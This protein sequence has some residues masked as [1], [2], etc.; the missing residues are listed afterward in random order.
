MKSILHDFFS[1]SIDKL[2]LS[3]MLLIFFRF[4]SKLINGQ[5]RHFVSQPLP[6]W[7]IVN[8]S[9]NIMCFTKHSFITVI[10]IQFLILFQQTF[11]FIILL[12]I[13][14]KLIFILILLILTLLFSLLLILLVALLW[15]ISFILLLF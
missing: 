3:S 8:F 12:L 13:Q 6:L 7:L 11:L 4:T 9:L 5:R 10:Y 2:I 15:I 14:I 1:F